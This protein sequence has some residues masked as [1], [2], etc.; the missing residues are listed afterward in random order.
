MKL[1]QLGRMGDLINVLPICRIKGYT[2]V[3]SR[4]YKNL[5]GDVE[6]IDCDELDLRKACEIVE[7]K[8]IITQLGS[9]TTLNCNMRCSNWQREQYRLAG[10]LDIFWTIYRGGLFKRNL[11][12]EEA[13]IDSIGRGK[14]LLS[15]KGVTS[16][17]PYVTLIQKAYPDAIDIGNLQLEYPYDL[18]GLF[19]VSKE[20]IT[21]DT[22]SLHL[23]SQCAIPY[24]A[25][26]AD[27]YYGSSIFGNC[28]FSCSYSETSCFYNERKSYCLGKIDV[29]EQECIQFV[30][31]QGTSGYAEIAK[32]RMWELANSGKKVK[33]KPLVVD[34]SRID[35]GPLDQWVNGIVGEW[36]KFD[37]LWLQT[38]PDNWPVLLKKYQGAKKIIGETIWE[39]DL[40]HPTWVK[41]INLVDEV[42]VSSKWN[43]EVF[44]KS[45]VIKPIIVRPFLIPKEE[46]SKGKISGLKDEYTFLTIGQW[47]IRKGISDTIEA[48]CCAFTAAD[49]V[50]LLVK[51]FERDY[52][53]E[54]NR[55]CQNWTQDI[56]DKHS[57]PPKVILLLDNI[58][59]QS[60]LRLH[61]R[62]DCYISLCKAE[63]WGLGAF[64]AFQLGKPIIITGYGGQ[65]EFLGVDYPGLVSYKMIPVAG[66]DWIT[67]YLPTQN[68]AQP[69]LEDAI[70]KMKK[71]VLA[72]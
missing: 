14:V 52:T 69:N 60:L 29:V 66:M 35:S 13:L 64:D 24:R 58:D 70:C 6:Y 63:G 37:T 20:L 28:I 49:S 3:T 41:N 27:G 38:T 4:K 48:F 26:I 43:K 1:I 68:W 18:L 59:R 55:R 50:A 67:A 42:V 53:Q 17:F 44:E 12:R 19:E 30:G 65:I 16:P 7:G 11:K 5:I 32:Y 51:T 23:A 54:S 10:C 72:I 40:L 9:R 8:K 22:F 2:L 34:D 46:S 33:F 47:T 31:S 71:L 36:E 39:T 15:L 56:L 62:A 25:F 45:G 61:Q 57:N 21:V